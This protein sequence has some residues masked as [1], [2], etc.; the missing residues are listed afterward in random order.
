MTDFK[1]NSAIA[2]LGTALPKSHQ[3]AEQTE[4]IELGQATPPRRAVQRFEQLRSGTGISAGISA[5]SGARR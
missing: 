2:D 4:L 1:A 5:G 3:P